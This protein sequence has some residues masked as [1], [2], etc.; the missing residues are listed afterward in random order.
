MT[1]MT[2]PVGGANPSEAI[3]DVFHES[4]TPLTVSQAQK[5]Y[6][7]PKL[8]KN[9]W[10]RI[11]QER[12]MQGQLFECSASGKSV[13]YWAYDEEQKVRETV[14]EA[15][16]VDPLPESKL[17][18]AVN[19]SLGKVSSPAAIKKYLLA[20]KLEK[21]L[22][23]HPGKGTAKT[24][25]LRP[26]S[27]LD[28]VQLK[29]GTWTDLVN[30]FGGVAAKG[31]MIDDFLALIRRKLSE[32]AMA[33]ALPG[34]SATASKQADPVA[35]RGDESPVRPPPPPSTEQAE[36]EQLILKGMLD[37]EPGVED[38]VP[39]SI[40]ILRQHM[41]P[42]YQKH[43]VFDRAVLRL[44]E[45]DRVIL[46]KQDDAANLSQAERDELVRDEYENFYTVIAHRT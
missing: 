20:M 8:A 5:L 34:G 28:S 39:V 21:R 18:T 45:E 3:L 17:V 30:V 2:A 41:P 19:K 11:I 44:A 33:P 35:T 32:T 36:V 10:P 24:L 9:D 15:L 26:P 42:E 46:H 13:R 37:I 4:P 14:Y 16:S 7:G 12:L 40:R 6:K 27:P 25:S 1:T 38:G 29:K 31:V 22:H 43:E 23:E